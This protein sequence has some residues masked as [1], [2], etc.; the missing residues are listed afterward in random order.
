MTAPS[1]VLRLGPQSRTAR[2]SFGLHGSREAMG[3]QGHDAGGALLDVLLLGRLQ[4]CLA[5]SLFIRNHWVTGKQRVNLKKKTYHC[6][7][8]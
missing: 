6:G 3:D 2:G 8:L 7:K 4:P 5:W 1:G